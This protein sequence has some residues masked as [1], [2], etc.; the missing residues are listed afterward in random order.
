MKII[1]HNND[2]DTQYELFQRLNTGGTNLSYQEVRNAI[3]LMEDREAFH[4][5]ELLS[6]M[7]ISLTHYHCHKSN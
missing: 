3:I 4:K 5:M 2:P 1:G 6:K 7:R